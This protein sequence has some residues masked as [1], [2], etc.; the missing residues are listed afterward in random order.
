MRLTT[1]NG[2]WLTPVHT[3]DEGGPR[4]LV[5]DKADKDLNTFI[6]GRTHGLRPYWAR[7]TG[8]LLR[9]AQ[10]TAGLALPHARLVAGMR[11]AQVAASTAMDVAPAA[12]WGGGGAGGRPMCRPEASA[13]HALSRTA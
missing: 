8:L 10:M 5:V 6:T 2:G 9:M 12:A 7:L 13:H 3:L 1:A 11:T 4:M